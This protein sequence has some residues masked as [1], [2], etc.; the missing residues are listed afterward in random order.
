MSEAMFWV[1]CKVGSRALSVSLESGP[2]G[3]GFLVLMGAGSGVEN[4]LGSIKSF[5]VF[6]KDQEPA[7]AS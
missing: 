3:A 7:A 1:R 2:L 5:G 6:V 4:A